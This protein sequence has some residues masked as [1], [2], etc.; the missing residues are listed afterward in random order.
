[1]AL[2]DLFDTTN[3]LLLDQALSDDD[4]GVTLKA[5]G[6]RLLD[7]GVPVARI[8]IGRSV[9]HPVIGLLDMQWERE[10]GQVNKQ[11]LTG[12]Q[13]L[14]EL[15]LD[16]PFAD[17][18][19]DEFSSITA[20][21]RDP[22]EIARYQIFNQLAASGMTSYAAFARKFGTR[23]K[24]CS[25]VSEHF[26]GASLSFATK[27][28]SGFFAS[29]LAGLER[30]VPA[31]CVCARV[32]TDMFMTHEVLETYLGRISGKRVLTGQIDRRDAQTIEC[33]LFYADMR[34]S[35]VLSQSLD[36][37]AYLDTVNAFFDGTANAVADHGGEVLKFIGDGILA[38]FP[39]EEGT[40]PRENMC[41]AALAAARE[42]VV[43]AT[44]SNK[45]RGADNLPPVE[46]GIALHVGEV[47]YG[48]VG[49]ERRLDFT[50]TGPEVGLAARIE[51]LTRSLD[52]AILASAAFAAQISEAG[53]THPPQHV[54]SFDQPIT[55]VSY[56]TTDP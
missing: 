32:D 16:D 50:A 55:V 22:K 28:F 49:V 30:L 37:P 4:F 7:G 8:S 35:L 52:A 15:H 53:N 26:R 17:L 33:A 56:P 9:P 46:F 27:R 21:L 39:I 31:I 19:R 29:D 2:S 25:R 10:T 1:M 45:V 11:T 14:S 36:T 48:N 34:G 24:L 5:L 23:Q 41:Q 42:A 40:R 38:I 3:D 12:A 18:S 54:R 43:R 6:T 20:D 51:A 13:V 47:I 44:H